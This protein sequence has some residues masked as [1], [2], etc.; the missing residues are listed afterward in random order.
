LSGPLSNPF[1]FNSAAD[2]GF[3][4]HQ[5]ANSCRFNKGDSPLLSMTPGAAGN[6]KIW[7]YS[8][9]IKRTGLGSDNLAILAQ[10]DNSGGG[11]YSSMLQFGS[12]N[13]FTVTTGT[14][15]KL[16]TNRLFRDPSAWYHIVVAAD[17]T[18][19]TDTNRWKIFI[20]GVDQTGELAT[21][22]YPAE[23]Y[24][25]TNFNDAPTYI[26]R[27]GGSGYSTYSNFMI[28]EAAF[29]DGTACNAATF[30]EEKNGVWIPKDLSGL[31]WGDEGWWLKFESSGDLGNDSSGNNNDFTAANLATHDQMLDSPTFSST[32][33]NGGN[34]CTL[35]P[36][37]DAEDMTLSEGNLTWTTSTSN[38]SINCNFKLPAGTGQKWY[39]EHRMISWAGSESDDC[40]LG[41][42]VIQPDWDGTDRG[43]ADSGNT[44]GAQGYKNTLGTETTSYGDQIDTGDV[45]GVAVDLEN[46]TI[47][48]YKEGAAQGAAWS[49]SGTTEWYPWIGSGGGSSTASGTFNFGQNGTFNGTETAGGNSDANGYG[50][51]FSSVPTGFKALCAGNLPIADEIDPAET[52]DDY[53]QKMFTALAYS[54][55]TT[56]HVTGFQPDLVWVKSRSTS[57]SNGL[58][59]STRGTTKILISNEQNAEATSSGLS[60]FNTDGYDMGTYYNQGANTYA[61]WSWRA[62][63]GTTSSNDDGTID[64][65]TQV[66]PSGCFSIVT[67][68]GNGTAG[69]ELGHGLSVAPNMIMVK[70]RSAVDSWAVYHSGMGNAAHLILDT[71]AAY[72]TSSAYWDS[73][74]PTSTVWTTGNADAINQNT[75][76]YVAYCFAN[77][78][79]YIKAGTYVGNGDDDGT[80]VYTG[81]RPAMM[82][83]K[84]YDQIDDWLIYDNERVGYNLD[85]AGNAV[86]Y[87]NDTYAEENQASRAIDILSNG[88]KLRTSNATGNASSGNYIYIAMAHNPFK[89]ATAR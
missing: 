30:A 71:T 61:S 6:K 66:D 3:Y 36:I 54:G 58:W 26:G 42:N 56:G 5:I 50:N 9:W 85:S 24:E 55:G 15:I 23:D 8:L 79:G 33:G 29:V 82:I 72:T 43:G 18:Q 35:N 44:Y 1:M 53:P 19:S 88:F 17:T 11:A 89:Y 48:F 25:F 70:N 68:T 21:A 10:D 87:P 80:F 47:Q 32:D 40:Y 57:Q 12:T 81:F 46:N 2:A 75:K 14:T 34:F 45:W 28:A 13:T 52:D 49:I 86:L 77:C 39:W 51:F 27:P 76:N 67:Y 37:T 78:E 22:T 69:E 64:T 4:T 84:E 16:I 74:D 20:N 38:R 59:D 60:A 41:I 62:N 65:V 83:L 7:A 63:G 31:T 73:T